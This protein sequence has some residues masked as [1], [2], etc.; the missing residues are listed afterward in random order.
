LIEILQDFNEKEYKAMLTFSA[1][2]N[3]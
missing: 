1:I 2:E 3:L